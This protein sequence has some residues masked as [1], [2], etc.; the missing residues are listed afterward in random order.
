MH[1][2]PIAFHECSVGRLHLVG[3]G[4]PRAKAKVGEFVAEPWQHSVDGSE[5]E[6]TFWN[7][8]DFEK[9]EADCHLETNAFFGDPE[10]AH[11]ESAALSQDLCGEYHTYKYE[12]TPEYIAWF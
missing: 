1:L 6:G 9:L 4:F 2:G 12:W 7:E 10:V 5:I 11:P 3:Q 8:L